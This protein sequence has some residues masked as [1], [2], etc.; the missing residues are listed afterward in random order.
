[1]FYFKLFQAITSCYFTLEFIE[2]F[3]S[4]YSNI[5]DDVSLVTMNTELIGKLRQLLNNTVNK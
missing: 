1:M 5:A 4:D 2:V 3:L